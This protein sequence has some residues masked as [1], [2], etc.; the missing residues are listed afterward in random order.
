MS[1]GMYKF[2]SDA[3]APPEDAIEFVRLVNTFKNASLFASTFKS[4]V[5][6][7]SVSA[8]D[9]FTWNNEM[10]ISRA[11]GRLDVMGGIADYSGSLVLQ[12]PIREATFVALERADDRTIRI[13]SPGGDQHRNEFFEM[14]LD[15]FLNAGKPIGYDEAREF[16]RREPSRH[17]AAYAA[18]V[19]LVLM[20]ERLVSFPGG[21]RMMISSK[22]PEGKGVS[23]SAAI[24]VAAMKA[25]AEAFK[26]TLDPRDL[27]ILCQKV[28]NLVVG[29]P[30]GVMDQM[31]SACGHAG[32]LMALLCQ[33]AELQEPVKIPDEIAFWGL[34]SGVRHSV[35]G[36]DY[37]S[38]RIGAF[39]GYRMIAELAG[40]KATP[41]GEG[42]VRID[43]PRWKGYLANVT[44]A[45]FESTF[46]DQLP[47]T[48]SGEEFLRCYSGTTDPVTRIDRKK[49]Y[50]VRVP[51][52]HPI[53]EH[54]RVR[55]FAEL[56]KTPGPVDHDRLSQLGKL[57][58]QSHQSYSA[59]GLGSEGTDRLVRLVERA[60]PEKGLFGAKITGGGSGG[61]VAVLGR[62]GSDAA[63]DHVAELYKKQ[64][65]HTPYIFSG[66]SEGARSWYVVRGQ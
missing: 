49:T 7:P 32:Q 59:C 62:K 5:E 2:V 53:Y 56:L 35:S 12:L 48:M 1:S 64:T 54:E 10:A 36:A 9:L 34:D 47:T 25:V 46:K 66:S 27:A 44:T 52:A 6:L 29:A 28:E 50:A 13:F 26:L 22:V 61:T 45:E 40:F 18:G 19:F 38:V 57:M 43:D 11:P 55:K 60:G 21:A 4:T 14:K 30:C 31:T 33:P 3:A 17:W 63:I 15:Q 41:I 42:L 8:A 37:G 58:V 23:S 24:E 20:R 39:M 16:F 51:T 65:G